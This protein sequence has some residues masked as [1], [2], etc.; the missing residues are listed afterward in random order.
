[1]LIMIYQTEDGRYL[2]TQEAYRETEEYAKL[3]P[4][5]KED[6]VYDL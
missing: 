3:T 6:E 1:M 2:S 5:Q 4:Q